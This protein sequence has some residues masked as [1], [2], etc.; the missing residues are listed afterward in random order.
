MEQTVVGHPI[1]SVCVYCGSGK[2]LDKR[3]AEAAAAL[4]R[5]LAGS[6]FRLVY[7]G[8]GNGLMGETAR[9]ALDCGGFVIGVIPENLVTLEHPFEDI[10]E[11]IVVRTLHQRKMLMFEQ[12][13]AFIALP[14]GL[15]TLEELI[16]QLTWAQLGHHQK[17]IILLNTAG[18]WDLLLEL[19]D[20]MR[21]ETFIRQGLS[22]KFSVA[23]TIEEVGA[24]LRGA[25]VPEAGDR[26]G[27]FV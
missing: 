8:G 16:E 1:R 18:Y 2:G 10:S 14:G 3:F 6:G 11:L 15:G 24:I 19:I 4:G 5:M 27:D 21:R 12:A 7:G 9:A 20:K 26:I 25:V 13:D 17:P 22:P 23:Q